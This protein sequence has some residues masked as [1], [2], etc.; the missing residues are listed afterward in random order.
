M[1]PNGY[2]RHAAL[3]EAEEYQFE[4]S[5]DVALPACGMSE[6]VNYGL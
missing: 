2:A 6:E 4:G 1:A 5:L 3:D